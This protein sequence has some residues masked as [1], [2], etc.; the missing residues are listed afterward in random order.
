MPNGTV[1]PD[2]LIKV[3]ETLQDRIKRDLDLPRPKTGASEDRTR[4]ALIDPL[5]GALGWSDPSLLTQEYVVNYQEYVKNRSIGNKSFRPRLADYALHH[6]D[7]PGR[8]IA[9]I[10]AKSMGT[11]LTEHLAQ[12]RGYAEERNV[13]RFVLT[14]GDRWELYEKGKPRPICTLSIRNQQASEC[15][16]LLLAHFP[17]SPGFEAARSA[18]RPEVAIPVVSESNA[19]SPAPAIQDHPT[20][21]SPQKTDFAKPLAWFAVCLSSFGVVGWITGVLAAQ[22]NQSV[23]VY[24][25]L[26]GVAGMVIAG[27][28]LV[29]RFFPSVLPVTIKSL[30][31]TLSLAPTT[32]G[33]TTAKTRNWI[34]LAMFCG[35]GGGGVLGHFIGLWTAQPVADF[36]SALGALTVLLGAIVAGVAVGTYFWKKNTD[37]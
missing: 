26:F 33:T 22:P 4:P 19:L 17:K 16:R 7:S 3:I 23:L 29:Q 5:L 37:T 30:I 20:L 35:A 15:A 34:V 27:I 8:L 9:F 32:S 11:P 2:P 36:L 6:R 10:E 14:N 1:T 24:I 31:S 25:G 21:K 12:V 18:N 28:L 13:H